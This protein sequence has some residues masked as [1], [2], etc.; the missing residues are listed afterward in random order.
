M[1]DHATIAKLAE[2]RRQIDDA[3][4]TCGKT[5]SA[6]KRARANA[7]ALAEA[8][9]FLSECAKDLETLAGAVRLAA[10]RAQ[11]DAAASTR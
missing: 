11:I 7:A 5:L 4:S 9:P 1:I 8:S 3:Q 10:E 6:M 2:L